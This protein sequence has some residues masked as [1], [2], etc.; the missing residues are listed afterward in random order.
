ML[1]E[2]EDTYFPEKV[3][4]AGKASYVERNQMMINQSD[5]CIFYY[6]GNYLPPRRKNSRMDL[7]DYQPNSGTKKAYEYAKKRDIKIKNM[8]EV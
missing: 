2:C 4:R 7:T 5:Y 8:F 3:S 6:D 1:K